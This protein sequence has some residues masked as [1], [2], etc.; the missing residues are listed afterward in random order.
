MARHIQDNWDVSIESI[1]KRYDAGEYDHSIEGSIK[2]LL[3]EIDRLETELYHAE[4]FIESQASRL[5]D[6]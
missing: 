4:K 6:L 5:Y 1:R 2:A 3:E